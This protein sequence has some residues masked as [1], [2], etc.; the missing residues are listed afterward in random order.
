MKQWN[1]KVEKNNKVTHHYSLEE[2]TED[3]KHVNA[4]KGG[5]LQ[6]SLLRTR[7]GSEMQVAYHLIK[8]CN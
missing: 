5:N 6:F 2:W 1:S 3:Q 8:K 7:S 4:V